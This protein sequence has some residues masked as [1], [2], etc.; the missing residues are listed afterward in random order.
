MGSRE[1]EKRASWPGCASAWSPALLPA[2]PQLPLQPGAYSPMTS[3]RGERLWGAQGPVKTPDLLQG[4]WDAGPML[5]LLGPGGEG[6]GCEG[7][8]ETVLPCSQCWLLLWARLARR[9]SSEEG[10]HGIVTE[11]STMPG[12]GS[13]SHSPK[14]AFSCQ[15][16]GGS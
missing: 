9:A 2:R 16:E 10:G 13:D 14:G 1:A 8:R 6:V 5:M 11:R 7:L 4:L 15:T 3:A 12:P